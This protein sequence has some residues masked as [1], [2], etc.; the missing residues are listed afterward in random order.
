MFCKNARTKL[1]MANDTPVP[2]AEPDQ[3]QVAAA[4]PQEHPP[5]TQNIQHIPLA[6]LAALQKEPQQ[7]QETRKFDFT[8]SSLQLLERQ[9]HLLQ[10]EQAQ[11]L[12]MYRLALANRTMGALS[13]ST[14][15]PQK[16]EGI[17]QMQ[18]L[19]QQRQRQRKGLVPSNGRASAA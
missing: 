19:M 17:Q 2:T 8:G 13:V 5:I 4:A 9:L 11:R 3:P 18:E 12:Y 16:T 6:L 15:Q 10:E 7:Q 14:P 1:A